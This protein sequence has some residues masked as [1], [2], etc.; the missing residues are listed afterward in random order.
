M[1]LLSR[2]QRRYSLRSPF[3]P[4]CGRCSTALRSD[5]RGRTAIA[6]VFHC[7]L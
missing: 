3:G 6:Q 1:K 5:G 4:T 7:R 2:R